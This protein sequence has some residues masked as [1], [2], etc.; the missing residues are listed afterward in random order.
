MGRT[1]MRKLT[2]AV[3][4]VVALGGIAT[5]LFSSFA[6]QGPAGREITVALNAEPNNLDP[7]SAPFAAN[8]RVTYSIFDT[9]IARHYQ[10]ELQEPERGLTLRPGLAEAWRRLDDRTLELTLRR[11]VTFHD[12]RALTSADVVFSLSKERIFGDNAVAVQARPYLGD[13]ASVQAIDAHT[14]RVASARPNAT[15]EYQLASPQAAIVPADAYA[16]GVDTFKRHPIG[17]GPLKF[18]RWRDG[19]R[20]EFEANEAYFGG[21]PNFQRLTFRFVPE[22][23]SRIAGLVSGEFDLIVQVTPDQIGVLR[24]YPDIRIA[25]GPLQS[26]Q[27]ILFD[28]R[29]AAVASP[30]IRQALSLAIDRAAIV[31]TILHGQTSIPTSWQIPEMGA[32]YQKDR[33]A[34]RYDVARA[35]QLLR[36]GGYN[37]EVITL[38]FPSGYYPN[39]DAVVQAVANMW[40][41][42]GVTTRIVATET[43][44]QITAGGSAASLIAFSYDMPLPEKA[45]C[46]YRG[47]NT[48]SARWMPSMTVFYDG[49]RVLPGV[50]QTEERQRLFATMLDDIEAATPSALLYQQPQA[51]A[52]RRTVRFQPYPHLVMDF[53]RG[54]FGTEEASH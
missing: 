44:G 28:T 32:I 39:G 47:P 38:R 48:W 41:A 27:E 50:F 11:D 7:A 34:L 23:S 18:K 13:I 49:C 29:H 5:I 6:Q 33:D 46:A 21:A 1:P 25:A 42:V 8:L 40:N 35:R 19:E 4:S 20:L 2:A 53:R 51:F 15:L 52:M 10:A 24:S 16:R 36:E 3:I 9:L 17:T 22:Q 14:V 43:I 45:V 37:G 26:T 30:A 54:A 31:R 12:G